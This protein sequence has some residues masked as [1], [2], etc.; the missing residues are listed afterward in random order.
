M[1]VDVETA[2]KLWAHVYPHLYQPKTGHETLIMIHSARTQAE[3]VPFKLRAWSHSWLLD[4]NYPSN[5][6]D[7]LKPAAERVYPRIVDAVG[8]SVNSTSPARKPLAAHIR[9]AMEYVVNDA[10][11]NRTRPSDERIR[12]MMM[13]ARVE[14]VRELLG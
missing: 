1:E 8:I 11:S 7:H 6:P 2:K 9:A 5:L 13:L 4:N 14:V 12:E 10:Y 3:S